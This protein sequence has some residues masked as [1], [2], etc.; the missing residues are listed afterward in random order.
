MAICPPFHSTAVLLYPFL[1]LLLLPAGLTAPRLASTDKTT[2]P[3]KHTTQESGLGL[4]EE[5]FDGHPDSKPEG[6]T[7][8]G[9]D[10]YF[11]GKEGG[12]GGE[13]GL[14][15]REN[16]EGFSLNMAFVKE[17]GGRCVRARRGGS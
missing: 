7:S 13:E 4:W 11:P 8:V 17:T 14:R 10:V 16:E 1:L 3:H 12:G 9:M 5:T 2:S 6:P 15:G